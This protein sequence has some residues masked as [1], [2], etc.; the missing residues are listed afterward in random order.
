MIGPLLSGYVARAAVLSDAAALADLMNR[1]SMVLRGR[2]F[3]TA[4][5][6][7]TLLTMPGFSPASDT[8]LTVDPD[9]QVVGYA[10]VLPDRGAGT[11]RETYLVVDPDHADR[12]IEEA[13]LGW[14]EARATHT[15]KESEDSPRTQ[16]A[17][18][19]DSRDA[20]SQVRLEAS[21][22]DRIRIFH[23]MEIDLG[24]KPPDPTW[25]GRISIRSLDP[26]TDLES[27]LAAFEEIF[28]DHWGHVPLP[29]EEA[30]ARLRHRIATHPDL[31]L[32]L[33]FLAVDQDDIAGICF[34][35]PRDGD[36][37]STGYIETLGIRRP[38]RGQGLAK[39]LLHHAFSSLREIGAQDAFLYV[40]SES[41]TG[42][43]RLYERVGMHVAEREFLYVKELCTDGRCHPR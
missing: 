13:L 1:H 16:I 20:G 15:Q 30:M 22:Y 25:P 28:A 18:Q 29:Q 40:D 27:A 37:A 32:S 35:F 38:W 14:I 17:Q 9:G 7:T 42:A 11:R 19:I 43:T 2:L 5:R 33:W 23:R 41:L 26:E 31:D 4:D 12:G 34:A 3:T 24:S 8:I 10:L 39:A 6:Q 21:G 36:E